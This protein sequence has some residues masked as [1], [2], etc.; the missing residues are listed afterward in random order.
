M[1]HTREV[2]DM[3]QHKP[4]KQYSTIIVLQEKSLKCLTNNKTLKNPDPFAQKKPSNFSF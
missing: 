3:I 2:T 1:I 4:F